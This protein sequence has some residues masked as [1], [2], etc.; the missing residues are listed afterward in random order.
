MAF[1]ERSAPFELP[2][3]TEAEL[4]LFA[5]LVREHCGLHYGPE[6]RFL[7]EQRVGRRVHETESGSFAA[8]HWKLRNDP[9]AGE[10][11]ATLIDDLTTNESYFLRER[12]QLEGLVDE[13]LPEAIA[14]R[15]LEGAGPAVVW[16]AGCASGEEPY[17]IVML[18]QERGLQPGVDFLVWGSDISRRALQRARRGL[19]R[20][21]AFRETDPTHRRRFFEEH[22]DGTQLVEDVRSR[23]ELLHLN[24]MD[25]PR[26]A[27][28]PRPDVIL[29]RN[30][31]IYFDTETRRRLVA[32]FARRLR[33]GG[34]LLVGRSESLM[35]V[36]TEFELRHLAH[37]VAHRLARTPRAAEDGGL[38][39]RRDG[40]GS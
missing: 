5:Q 26:F 40:E 34:H 33:P 18:A 13:I 28:I 1:P 4:R 25:G 29:C 16:S 20:D 15:R 31:M 12:E 7:L 11:L 2:S 8:Y 32:R 22:E 19:Y 10:E 35:H 9:R 36:T 37:D 39:Q 23:V 21:A 6:T 24:L 27:R 14:A 30:V 38:V 17:S 3:M